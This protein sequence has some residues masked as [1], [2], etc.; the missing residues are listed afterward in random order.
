MRALPS[1]SAASERGGTGYN[2]AGIIQLTAQLQRIQGGVRRIEASAAK[3][4]LTEVHCISPD[5]VGSMLGL[6]G[7]T[8]TV[9]LRFIRIMSR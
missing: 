8:H 1:E 6:R 4:L 9:T 5:K 7:G 2:P 3:H